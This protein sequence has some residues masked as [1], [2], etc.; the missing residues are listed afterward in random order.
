MPR[1]RV[2]HKSSRE[3]WEVEAGDRTGAVRIVGWPK[4]VCKV[5]QLARGPYAKIN[6]PKVA[7]QI[8]PPIPGRIHICPDCNLTLIESQREDFWWRCPS[9]D[10]YYNEW[11]QKI[12]R[13]GEA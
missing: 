11:E 10:L 9:C 2:I 1:F 12:I 8:T 6:P 7:V 13:N 5:V 3:E 4:D